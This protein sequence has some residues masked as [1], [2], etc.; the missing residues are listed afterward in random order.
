VTTKRRATTRKRLISQIESNK[1][2][3]LAVGIKEKG[4]SRELKT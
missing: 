1:I 2:T 4:L 3:R